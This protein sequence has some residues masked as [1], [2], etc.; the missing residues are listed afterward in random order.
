MTTTAPPARL[1]AAPSGPRAPVPV[2]AAVIAVAGC[3]A[4][5]ARPWTLHALDD[6]VLPLVIFF[7]ALGV[8]G[9]RWPLPAPPPAGTQRP[10]SPAVV[11]GVGLAAFGTGRLL[12][13]DPA[14]AAPWPALA[15]P[16][17]LHGLAAVAEEA[18]F[19]GLVFGLLERWGPAVAVGGSA[20][21]F[22]AVHVTVWG[23]WVLPLDLAA[24]LVLSWQ[25]AASGHW[26][27]PAVTHALAN[28]W[29]LA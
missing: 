1:R 14:P 8:V 10:L 16:L 11:I 15:T 7:V 25:R 26:A 23:W 5:L 17:L 24:G 21:A 27:V 22:A 3:A 13:G 6:P 4:L 29:A 19:R 18:F 9:A 12:L 28:L 2:A 20:L